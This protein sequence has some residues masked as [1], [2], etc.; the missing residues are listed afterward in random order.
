MT[1]G[2]VAA[3]LHAKGIPACSQAVGQ[4]LRRNPHPIDKPA[5]DGFFVPCHRVVAAAGAGRKDTSS[6]GGFMGQRE[7]AAVERKRRL[8]YAERS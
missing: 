3:K 4:A 5:A 6:I 7:G 2:E 8:L 1:Y